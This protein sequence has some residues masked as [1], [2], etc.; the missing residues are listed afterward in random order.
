MTRLLLD[1]GLSP[2]TA[3]LLN[4]GGL[5]TLHVSNVALDRAEDLDIL[6]YCLVENRVC[7]TLDHDFHA[8]LA[9]LRR[10]GPS[11]IL[12]RVEG[13][14][15]PEQ[16]ALIRGVWEACAPELETGAAVSADRDSI[17]IRRLPLR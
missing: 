17:R 13:L 1:Q 15:A 11:V 16:A 5:D 9:L 12:L 10:H 14:K 8:H 7:V 2:A 6:E 4:E 3:T